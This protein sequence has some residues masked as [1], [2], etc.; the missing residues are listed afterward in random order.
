[1]NLGAGGDNVAQQGFGAFNVEG[2]IIV[3]EEDGNLTA[4]ALGASFEEE[5]FIHHAFVGAKADGV[6]KKSGYREELAAIR[7]AAPRLHRN[8]AQCTPAL[9]TA[10][11]G[12]CCQLVDSIKLVEVNFVPGN[13]RILL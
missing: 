5:Q 6:A 4:F 7:A 3:D 2:E 8:D 1:M 11:K 10:L 13:R 12:A 9:P